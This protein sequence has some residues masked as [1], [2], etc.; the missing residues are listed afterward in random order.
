MPLNRLIVRF[1]G[2]LMTMSVVI[3]FTV[4]ITPGAQGNYS[5]FGQA[6]VTCHDVLPLVMQNL[7]AN[8]GCGGLN[9]SQACYANH[10]LVVEY[11]ALDANATPPSFSQ[12]GNVAALDTLKSI[13]TSP[14]NLERGEWGVAFMKLRADLPGTVGGAPVSFILYGDTRLADASR[15]A[16]SVDSV[17]SADPS[18]ALL[19]PMNTFYLSNGVNLHPSCNDVAANSLPAGGLLI[20]SPDGKK[21]R[22]TANGAEIV[23]ASGLIMRARANDQMTITVLHGHV[24]VTAQGRSVTASAFQ[25]IDVPL[26]GSNGLTARRPVLAKSADIEP[27]VLST[28]CRLAEAADLS[29]TCKTAIP[30]STPHPVSRPQVSIPIDITVTPTPIIITVTPTPFVAPAAI[31]GPP[32]I[33]CD[34]GTEWNPAYGKCTQV[35]QYGMDND[36][37]SKTYGECVIG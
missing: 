33:V 29:F 25:E 34:A 16:D 3:G 15:Q 30:T 11:G 17:A 1:V 18:A 9:P 6:A 8:P 22:F 21:V 24:T 19:A 23:I 32:A 37:T 4:L 14:L 7:S 2:I 13:Q 31:S 10:Q 35:C 26:G 36:P 27:L 5:V 28:V 12:P 20:D